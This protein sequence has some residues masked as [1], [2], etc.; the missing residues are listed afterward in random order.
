MRNIWRDV[1]IIAAILAAVSLIILLMIRLTPLPPEGEMKNAMEALS[2][3]GKN[4]ADIYSRKQY[5]EAK[6]Y[7]DSA[8]VN[9]RKQNNRFIYIRNYSRVLMFAKLSARQAMA[10]DR[11]SINNSSNLKTVLKQKIDALNDLVSE[12]NRLFKT[13]PLS[14]MTFSRISKGKLLL[15]EAEIIYNKGLYFQSN[16]KLTDSEYLLT[17]SNDEANAHLKNYF[18][19]FSAWKR[20]VTQTINDSKK[21]NDYSIIVDKFSRKLYVYQNGA[22]KMEYD[23][24]LGTNWVGDKRIRGDN[25]TPE[26]M[27]K[28]SKKFDNPRTE[29][30]KALLINYP[31]DGDVQ[32]FNSDV[33][34]GLLPRSAK[35]GGLIEIHGNGGKGID[36]T[37]GCIALTDNE[38][39]IVFELAKVG[40]PVTIV[41]S[42]VP[43]EN[44][45]NR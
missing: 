22:R 34:K 35:I 44:I 23:A 1:I 2:R 43:L 41:G 14:S 45:V 39:D 36:W 11:N 12:I 9:W 15:K 37:Q 6:T 13:Y 4:N 7:Y 30:Y 28:I 40:T 5:A 20:W 16:R 25:A 18:K 21:N 29:Y 33:A 42:M 38:M 8:M 27:Y 17:S 10:A 31:N 26:G 24:E 19:S 32:K 3:A